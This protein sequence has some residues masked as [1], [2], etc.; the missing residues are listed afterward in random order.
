MKIYHFQLFMCDLNRNAANQ[1]CAQMQNWER[2]GH[3]F[4]KS[5]KNLGQN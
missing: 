4:L 1:K 5:E 2:M 3:I